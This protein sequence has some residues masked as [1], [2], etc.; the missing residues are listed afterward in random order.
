MKAVAHALFTA[1]ILGQLVS[2]QYNCS[3]VC[4]ERQFCDVT[5]GE[6]VDIELECTQAD[7]CVQY[8]LN[9]GLIDYHCKEVVRI[10][11]RADGGGKESKSK[12]LCDRKDTRKARQNGPFTRIPPGI[13]PANHKA[14]PRCFGAETCCSQ[15]RATGT[16]YP[17]MQ[18]FK[19]PCSCVKSQREKG[20]PDGQEN[21]CI[22]D[23]PNGLNT[24]VPGGTRWD[25]GTPASMLAIT[26]EE[27][28]ITNHE[29]PAI[30]DGDFE[31]LSTE[32][33]NVTDSR[34]SEIEPGAFRQLSGVKL[35]NLDGNQL[36]GVP[37]VAFSGLGP[38]LTHL[39]MNRNPLTALTADIFLPLPNLARLELKNCAIETLPVGLFAGLSKLQALELDGNALRTFEPAVFAPLK[40]LQYL[41]LI[42]NKLEQ[43]PSKAFAGLQN[44]QTLRLADNKLT[45]LPSTLFAP[46]ASLQRL[47]LEGNVLRTLAGSQFRSNKNLQMLVLSRNKLVTV[48][49]GAFDGLTGALA[50]K[51]ELNT[52]EYLP[53]NLFRDMAQLKEL[54]LHSNTFT[55]AGYPLDLFNGLSS[56]RELRLDENPSWEHFCPLPVQ[57]AIIVD[58]R[59]VSTEFPRECTCEDRICAACL[60][61]RPMWF[62]T[63]AALVIATQG[64]AQWHG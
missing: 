60:G 48:E 19:D 5:R 44:L 52:I 38:T 62:V 49:P 20:C 3:R 56:L 18:C 22:K 27:V 17:R 33:L 64:V 2:A 30:L 4:L 35:L 32:K 25:A 55:A 23:A 58:D 16:S 34:V 6:C 24:E 21:A 11:N 46:L 14:P 40:G 39:M 10:Y 9:R 28:L 31:G 7:R 29:I 43:L 47:S 54:T 12:L 63:V 41:Y 51:M 15:V 61:A 8:L 1:G 53:R 42:G 37:V 36:R 13:R 59:S 45:T 57:C 26:I 50:V